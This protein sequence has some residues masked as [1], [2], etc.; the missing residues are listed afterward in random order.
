MKLAHAR[1]LAADV[2]AWLAPGCAAVEV[3]GSIRRERPECHDV[4][5]AILPA[6]QPDLFGAWAA[7]L[8]LLDAALAPVLA[9]RRL[10]WHPENPARGKRLKRLWCPAEAATIELWIADSP[11]N[12]GPTLAIRTGDANFAH[13][14]VTPRAFGGF[15]PDGWR[16]ADGYL[17]GADGA[18]VPC[19]TEDDYFRQLGIA[20]TPAPRERDV[21]LARR[22]ARHLEV[23]R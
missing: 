18:I 4:E 23:P 15:M 22:L 16:Q 5:L 6:G 19:P 12:W 21:E 10:I 3:A 14:L 13:A 20:P 8:D 9:D 1:R 7:R 17:H 2:A 11:D